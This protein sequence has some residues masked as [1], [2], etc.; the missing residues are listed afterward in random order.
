MKKLLMASLGVVLIALLALTLATGN[1][2]TQQLDN[3]TADLAKDPRVQVISSDKDSGWLSSRGETTL[4]YVLDARTNLLV[5]SQWQASHRPG[6]V[7]YQGSIQLSSVEEGQES[8]DLLDKLG[9]DPLP[10]HG[11]AGWKQASYILDLQA[12]A[13]ADKDYSIEFS[14]GE[15]KAGYEYATGHQTGRLEAASLK[16]GGGQFNPSQLTFEEVLLSWNQQGIYPW[17]SGDMHLNLNKLHFKGPQ[18]EVTFD[19]PHLSQQLQITEQNF[20]LSLALDTG[21]VRS[22][23]RKL[24]K[25]ALALRTDSF[26]GQ[27]TADLLEFFSQ[28]ADWEGLSEEAMQPGLAA[29]N[30]LLQGSPALL[31]DHLQISLATP[32]ELSQQAEGSIGFDGRNLPTEYLN[33]ISSGEIAEDDLMSRVRVEFLFDKIN[34]ELLMLVG[35]PPFLQDESAAQQSLIWEAGELRLNGQRLPF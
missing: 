15:L 26:D 4:A 9:V 6:W 25:A 33:R 32:V 16:L 8:L 3:I 23:D 14:G 24:G 17:V 19:Q 18:G 7:S 12:L 20:D 10:F 13:L 27:A 31:L 29:M 34:P 22:G 11:R 21:E 5:T 30:Q 28:E 1:T 2:F 35:I